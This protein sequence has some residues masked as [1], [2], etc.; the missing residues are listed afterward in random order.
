[1]HTE[2]RL[3]TPF[4]VF[5][6]YSSISAPS[7]DISPRSF[8]QTRPDSSSETDRI[9]E[10]WSRSVCG[11]DC[12]GPLHLAELFLPPS[13][14]AP[15]ADSR[16]PAGVLIPQGCGVHGLRANAPRSSGSRRADATLNSTRLMIRSRAATTP[17]GESIDTRKNTSYNSD[18]L[19]KKTVHS[20]CAC[21]TK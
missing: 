7:S 5:I 13:A 11:V 9:R 2:R 19:K 4:Y 16:L 6:E 21:Y 10:W 3:Q 14:R 12:L 20:C 18:G 1:M 15:L 17:A 8:R